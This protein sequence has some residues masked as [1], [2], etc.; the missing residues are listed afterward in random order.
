VI[1][2]APPAAPETIVLKHD[3]G[4][5]DGERSLGASGHFVKLQCPQGKWWLSEVR[6]YG[7]RYGTPEPPLDQFTITLC[8]NEFKTLKY[9]KKPYSIFSERG[10]WRDYP[11][12]VPPLELPT[13][14]VAGKELEPLALWI[15]VA[16]NPSSTKGVYVGYDNS[17]LECFSKTGLP[18]HTPAE[19]PD[20]YNWM[21]RVVITNSPPQQA[22]VGLGEWLEPRRP[23]VPWD[24]AGLIELK[25]DDGESDGKQSMGA[26]GPAVRFQNAP[27]GAKLARLRLYGS[28]YGS[29]YDP[30][31]TYADYYV[32]DD[33][34]R[35]I[36]TGRIPYAL[37]TYQERWVDV[38]LKPVQV[39]GAFSVLI[40]PSAHQY[41]G[42]YFH[43]DKDVAAAH[44]KYGRMPEET[45]D[46]EEPW[47]WMIR[48][49]V[50][51]P[52]PAAQ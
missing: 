27:E 1:A 10:A 23:L 31:T 8:D 36:Q 41:K 5:K 13:R 18:D 24:K 7:A 29:G 39:P 26:A 9:I 37:F 21:I 19:I 44:S 42:I 25:N 35:L 43:Y 2:A 45:S 4:S 48:A 22:P 12:P 47:D 49:Y 46:L 30:E 16:F 15:N 17:D 32:Y 38:P 51:V 33:G 14:Q 52:K 34:L 3:D 50:E 6:I 40:N 20:K 28:R 11:V